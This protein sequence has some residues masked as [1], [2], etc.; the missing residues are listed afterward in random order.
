MGESPADVVITADARERASGILAH[1][2]SRAGVRLEIAHLAAA[3][4]LLG[5]GVAAERKSARDFVASILDRR[6][7]GQ[8]EHLVEAFERPLLILEGDPL[9]TEIAVHPNAVLG[10]LAHL[11]VVRRLPVL[12]STGLEGTADLLVAIARHVQAGGR[13]ERARAP[14]KRRVGSLADRQE[15]IAA[16][17][18]GVGPVLAQRLLHRA[19][20]LAALAAADRPLLREVPGIGPR[21]AEVLNTLFTAPY[22]PAPEADGAADQPGAQTPRVAPG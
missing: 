18:P 14:A 9:S 19:G 20:S 6:L 2:E 15:A 3:D 13:G 12:P 22:P 8:A 5:D 4:F 7:F 11:A 1:L 21:R 16:A 10:A 17:L